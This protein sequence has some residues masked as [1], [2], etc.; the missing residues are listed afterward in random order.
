MALGALGLAIGTIPG[1]VNVPITLAAAAVLPGG[2]PVTLELWHGF[3]STLLLSAATL[4]ITVC[5]FV[6]RVPIRNHAWPR[7]LATERL[8]TR[9]LSMLDAV[10]DVAAP[11]F[12]GAS[13]R[14]YVLT[15]V[16]TL[17]S[18]VGTALLTVRVM[19]AL[20]RW[21][22]IQLHEAAV[23]LLIV[24]AAV[25]AARARATMTAVLSLGMVGYG[26]SLLYVIF[27]APDLGI[28]QF[29]VE[30]LTVVIFVLVFRQL[31]GFGDLSSPLVKLRDG[32]IATATGAVIAVLVLFIGAS[33]TTSRL[34]SYFADVAPRLGH[35]RNVVNVILVDFRAFDTL[36]EI[37]VLVTVAV[38]VVALLRIAKEG[39]S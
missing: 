13:V 15:I 27:G 29:A 1:L 18:L 10:S 20:S 4:A 33:G 23:A 12:Q 16:L 5:L 28:T 25:A 34:S 38:G 35:G 26:V 6:F 30:T 7:A 37:T 17:V 11:A 19:P 8:Y 32:V 31:R 9:A 2:A 21:T 36:G 39:R 24:V 14:S 22:P 3:G